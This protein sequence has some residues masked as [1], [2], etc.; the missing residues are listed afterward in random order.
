MKKKRTYHSEHVE[1]VRVQDVLPMLVGGCIVAL[2]VAKSKFVV[3]LATLAG[4][5]LKL[6][7]FEHP[8]ETRTFLALVEEL[9][10]ALGPRAK[11]QV[12]MEPTG[13]YGDAVRDRLALTGVDVRMV[14]PKKTFD[15]REVFDAVPSLHDPKSAAL[16]A[17]LCAMGLSK[18]YVQVTPSRTRLRALVDLRRHEESALERCFGR[19]EALLARHWPELGRWMNV[20]EHK[21]GLRLLAELGSPVRVAMRAG[22][23]RALLSKSSRGQFGDELIE[24]VIGSARTTLGVPMYG[25]HIRLVEMIAKQALD[26][27]ER[28]DALDAELATFAEHD[29]T[30]AALASWMGGYT[31]AVVVT[32]C[33]L[34]HYTN[35]AQLEK[36]CGLNLREKSSG[37]TR[38]QLAITKRGPSLVRRVLFMFAL[39]MIQKSPTVNAWYTRRRGYTETSKMRAVV[40]VM[41]K[42][43]R[44]AFHVA[45]GASFDET[46]L[47]ETRRLNARAARKE[48]APSWPRP[49]SRAA[50]RRAETSAAAT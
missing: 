37:E 23:A 14:S 17:K 5:V 25:E 45:R 43:A 8:E 30:Y 42:L 16:I 41:R 28:S 18:P 29:T 24:A 36:G 7:R 26:A 20:R 6:L 34:E 38:G 32:M 44:A 9:S 12:A 50:M 22:D 31:G 21:T 3:A 47:F 19:L 27:R 1:Q 40:A 48:T 2:D 10:R 4:D 15:S 11:I 49:K 46:K 13:T 35:A 33:D 39:R